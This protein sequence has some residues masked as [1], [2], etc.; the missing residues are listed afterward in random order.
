[1]AQNLNPVRL[2]D[3]LVDLRE[4][5]D[6]EVKNWLDLEGNDT[7]KAI[8]AKA[9]LA[10]ANHGGGFIILGFEE[11]EGR[12]VE[13]PNRPPALDRYNQDRINGI[14]QRYS[15]PSFH[16]SVH[17]VPR[18]DGAIY[19]VVVVPG[20][21]RIP[22]RARRDGPNGIQVSNHAIYIRKPGPRSEAPQN[23]QEWDALLARCLSNRRD[24]MFDQIRNLITGSTPRDDDAAEPARLE[25]WIEEG[26]GRW[27]ALVDGIPVGS[28]PRFP[29]GHY[30]FAY[31]IIGD[32][33]PVGLAQLPDV[34]RASVVRHTGW[35]PF[36]YPNRAG[37]EP[38]PVDGAVECW[39]G[40]DPDTRPEDRD[41]AH[42]DFW[43]IHHEGLAILMRGHDE[44]CMQDQRAPIA[45]GTVFDICLPVWRVGEAL[46][47]AEQ[48]AANL[49][50]GPASIQFVAV[51]E[52][53]ANRELVSVDRRR[54]MH[55]GRVAHQNTIR[56]T[57]HVEAS[58]ITPNLPEIVTP[59]LAP[60][61]ELFNFFQLPIQLV[62]EEL[63]RMRGVR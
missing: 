13:A 32:R 20:G 62:S 15:D 28:G 51:Y 45:P 44:D 23:S 21:H 48:L 14:V 26:L 8:F 33:R 11:A 40:G 58:A 61:Y 17:L 25:R 34:I 1:M 43:R 19:P 41:A 31:E 57:S 12:F 18:P 59:L 36:W 16:C 46:L 55:D 22:V 27:Q 7:D 56:L 47:Q 39:L 38:Y 30:R 5:L 9:A 50:E 52:G 6:V 42:S 4:G 37:I 53:L 49:F 24:E 35:P 54:M 29:H 60:L 3:L 2:A 63:A 10:L